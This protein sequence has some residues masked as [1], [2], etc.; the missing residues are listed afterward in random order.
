MP[1]PDTFDPA[2]PLKQSAKLHNV[3]VATA[4]NWRQK[5][6]YQAPERTDLWTDDE[7]YRLKTLYAG[8]SLG[9]IAAAIGRTESS[10]KSMAVKLGLRKATG[11]FAPD[12]APQIRGRVQG[13]A[14]M[15]AQHLQKYAPV[16][17]CSPDG[18]PNPK[19]SCWRYGSTVLTEAEMI[20][21]AER[22]GWD[23]DAWKRLG[24]EARRAA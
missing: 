19:G 4:S 17:R 21:R 3:S 20:A 9:H 18:S 6:G 16:F 15:A 10:V 23:A 7:I 24:P 11:N 12:R 14:D 22:K 13:H 2:R 5:L 8:N 1:I